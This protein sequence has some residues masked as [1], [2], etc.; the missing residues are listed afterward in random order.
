MGSKKE[1]R[2]FFAG[3]ADGMVWGFIV[4]TAIVTA[5]YLFGVL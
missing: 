3:V 5:L 2:K 4:A 1:V